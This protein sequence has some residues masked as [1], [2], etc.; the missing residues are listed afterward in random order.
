MNES[1]CPGHRRRPDEVPPEAIRVSPTYQT[2][3]RFGEGQYRARG[4]LRRVVYK[5]LGVSVAWMYSG[6]WSEWRPRG[7]GR[8]RS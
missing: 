4:V 2:R 7:S 5:G 8:F 3:M 6:S 1:E